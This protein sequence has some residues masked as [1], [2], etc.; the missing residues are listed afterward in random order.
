[1]NLQS[2][3]QL[4]WP[5]TNVIEFTEDMF[6]ILPFKWVSV[7]EEGKQGRSTQD[8]PLGMNYF[9]NLTYQYTWLVERNPAAERQF[10][11]CSEIAT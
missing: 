8:V 7:A 1:M 3:L 5:E 2:S 6:R 11:G 9:D 4:K 10:Q